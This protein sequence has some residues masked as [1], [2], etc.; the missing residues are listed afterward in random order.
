MASILNVDEANIN[1]LNSKSGSALL[2]NNDVEVNGTI[3]KEY[4]PG[5]VIEMLSSP[6][7]GSTVEGI[8][9]SY[10][11][12]NVSAF[13]NI[14]S[15]SYVDLTGSEISY[16]P[17]AG[18]SKVIYDLYFSTTAYDAHPI[19]HYKFYIDADEVTNA[20]FDMSARD[21]HEIKG[22]LKWTINIGGI[23]D[24]DTGRQASWTVAKTLK[25]QVRAYTG[26]SQQRAHAL[27]YWDGV[28]ANIFTQPVLTLTAI[29]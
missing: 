22:S 4:R 12:P 2:L 28:P 11:W 18:A 7:D 17:P 20:R 10:T 13:Q 29:G 6:C 26:S 27:R 19:A 24:T 15:T 1:K 23:A 5:E 14:L 25:V 21:Y 8:S 9:G 3:T 16:L